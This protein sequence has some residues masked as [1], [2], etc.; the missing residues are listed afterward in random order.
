[1]MASN[2]GD[3]QMGHADPAAA[4]KRKRWRARNP[5]KDRAHRAVEN[6]VRTLKRRGLPLP[7]CKITSLDPSHVCKGAVHAM[8]HD[9]SRPL[10]VEWACGSWHI[11]HHWETQWRAERNGK[12]IHYLNRT[13]VLEE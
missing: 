4:D 7:T 11:S 5:E 2:Q 8:H 6:F 12:A 3:K 10:D 9:Y 1:M 13:I